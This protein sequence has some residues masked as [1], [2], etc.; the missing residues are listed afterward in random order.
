M[1]YLPIEQ[2]GL[3]GK[4]CKVEAT[5]CLLLLHL[6]LL[7]LLLLLI[8]LLLRLIRINLAGDV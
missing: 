2:F 8:L 3:P 5:L 6:L 1:T 4:M 7:L